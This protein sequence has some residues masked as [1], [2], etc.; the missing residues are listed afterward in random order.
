MG[1]KNA[2]KMLDIK[3]MMKPSSAAGPR[4]GAAASHVPVVASEPNAPPAK[5][6]RPELDSGEGISGI[7]G[8]I[9]EDNFLVE[10]S[11]A[12]DE[13]DVNALYGG[14]D[15]ES[16]DADRGQTTNKKRKQDALKEKK[17]LKAGAGPTRED[18]LALASKTAAG[19]ADMFLVFFSGE[20]AGSTC[21]VSPCA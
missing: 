15:E 18:S 16:A 19:K 13:G 7:S 1:K 4:P 8:D 21:H 17:R 14:S 20:Y 12:G 5:R 11:A 10:N 9:L 6:S 2:S 3:K